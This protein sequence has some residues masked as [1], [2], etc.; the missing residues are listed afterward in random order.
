[1]RHL[2]EVRRTSDAASGFGAIEIQFLYDRPPED[3]QRAIEAAGLAVSVIDVPV[4]DM[5]AGGPGDFRRAAAE[6]WPSRVTAETLSWMTG[7]R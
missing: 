2:E 5:L 6:Y 3:W 7:A 1:M 4:G